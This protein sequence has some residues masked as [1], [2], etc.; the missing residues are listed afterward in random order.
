MLPF[1]VVTQIN[2]L[3]V[4]VIKRNII[5]P[6]K[7]PFLALYFLIINGKPTFF[8]ILVFMPVLYKDFLSLL[9]SLTLTEK[10]IPS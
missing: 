2:L 3:K 9:Y 6:M 5:A 7:I 8:F 1:T 10:E 4:K